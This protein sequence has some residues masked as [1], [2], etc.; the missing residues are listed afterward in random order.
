M[1]NETTQSTLDKVIIEY[2]ERSA[3][4]SAATQKV[5]RP[6]LGNS[7]K[8]LKDFSG[9]G[10]KWNINQTSGISF[11]AL[12]E[13]DG[14][15][16]VTNTAETPTQRQLV[17]VLIGAQ[18]EV[19]YEGWAFSESDFV[20]L[21]APEVAI[22]DATAEDSAATISYAA[23]YTEAPSSAPDHEIGGTQNLDYPLI[24]Q[25]W[26]LLR[27][28]KAPG[29]YNLFLDPVQVAHLYQDTQCIALLDKGGKVPSGMIGEGV[30][31]DMFVGQILGVNIWMV[32]G[33][34][35]TSTTLKAMMVAQDAIGL[36]YKK[37]STPLSPTPSE[38]NIDVM[39]RP[40]GRYFD[41]DMT[42][43]R[44]VGGI[45]KTNTTNNRVVEI[46]TNTS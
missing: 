24:R 32:P 23:L 22:A 41:V 4:E 5:F 9:P 10:D 35:I 15:G 40:K 33:G 13:W 45:V 43:C 26:Q 1:A 46:A 21:I 16:N 19:S 18:M 37:I 34:M 36:A 27:T 6:V 2:L 38:L 20:S 7:P 28:A 3:V 30:R 44:D 11:V 39:W 31:M 29:P 17:P 14:T 42:V 25:A 12:T 8:T